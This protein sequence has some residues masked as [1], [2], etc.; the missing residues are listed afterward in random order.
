MRK[1]FEC[2][3]QEIAEMFEDADINKDGRISYAEYLTY[4]GSLDDYEI[5]ENGIIRL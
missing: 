1:F 5:D 3:E 2:T 4:C